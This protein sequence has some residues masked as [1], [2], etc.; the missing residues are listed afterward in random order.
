MGCAILLSRS[1]P[2]DAQDGW[3]Y[4]DLTGPLVTIIHLQRETH[5]GEVTLHSTLSDGDLHSVE[6][7]ASLATFHYDF[8]S[9]ERK[10]A[11]SATREGNEIL[12]QGTL[13]GRP[14]SRRIPIDSHP[15]YESMELSLQKLAVS[16]SPGPLLF[17]VVHPYEGQA[18]L[19]QARQETEEEIPWTAGPRRRC[20][21]G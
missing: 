17:W 5:D 6:M 15:W 12:L 18:F 16:G 14:L 19:M 11:Y 20:G 1:L 9:P 4:R 2:A 13:K 10:T 3:I 7:D 21:S 8:N